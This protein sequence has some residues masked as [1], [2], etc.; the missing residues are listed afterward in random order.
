MEAFAEIEGHPSSNIGGIIE[1]TQK[2]DTGVQVNGSI[3]GLPGKNA[4]HGIAI[5]ENTSC[6][7]RDQLP[8][9]MK[10]IHHYD[11]F[12]S[13]KHGSR[14][15]DQYDNYDR[16]TTKHIG[17]LGNIFVQFD[18]TSTFFFEV[19]AL[20]LEDPMST[21]ANHTIVI[22][23]REDNLGVDFEYS[24]TDSV[25]NAGNAIACGVIVSKK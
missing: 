2:D 22:M 12:L 6:P 17:D 8:L 4:Y 5:L 19:S 23:E 18:G 7:P 15:A 16:P 24:Q 9:D 3:E 11:P 25:G 13:R 1:F 14:F 20:S 21:I 10:V